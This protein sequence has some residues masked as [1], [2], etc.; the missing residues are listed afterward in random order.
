MD[1][2]GRVGGVWALKYTIIYTNSSYLLEVPTERDILSGLVLLF[3]SLLLIQS[4][5]FP[6]ISLLNL[7]RE[8][9]PKPANIQ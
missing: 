9:L 2:L 4:F 8:H 5:I 3:L 1:F 6:M 7:L